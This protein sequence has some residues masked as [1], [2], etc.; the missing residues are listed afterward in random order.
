M[1]THL[2]WYDRIITFITKAFKYFIKNKEQN[3]PE[4]WLRDNQRIFTTQEQKFMQIY[5][6]KNK[7]ENPV[8]SPVQKV[9]VIPSMKLVT[10]NKKLEISYKLREGFLSHTR[11]RK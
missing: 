2:S 9:P 10:A 3:S 11:Y 5:N 8:S 6:Y 7:I 1:K 4:I